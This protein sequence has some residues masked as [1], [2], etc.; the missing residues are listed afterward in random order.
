M[1]LQLVTFIYDFFVCQMLCNTHRTRP[2]K[3]KSYLSGVEVGASQHVLEM[4]VSVGLR[5]L[6]HDHGIS[7]SQE[8]TRRT[9]LAQ[10]DKLKH[11]LE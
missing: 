11:N 4:D 6:H 2:N 3:I 7:L 5:L 8:G 1:T 9:Q 10:L